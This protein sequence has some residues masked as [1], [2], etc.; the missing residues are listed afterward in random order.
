M[1]IF[2][3][4]TVTVL[5]ILF[6]QCSLN[7]ESTDLPW[8]QHGPLMVNPGSRIIHHR[9]GTP[10]LWLG[11]TAWGM[12]EWLTREDVDYYLNDRKSK[13]MNV[14][15]LCLFWG[16]RRDYPTRFTVNAENP[17]GH[18]AFLETDEIPDPLKPAIVRGGSADDPNDYWDHVD[19]C[20]NATQARGMVAAVLPFWG[21]RYVNASHADQSLP[22]FTAENI[23]QYTEFLGNRYADRPNIIWVNG[24]DVRADQN[25]DYL[26]LYRLAAEGLV[27]GVTGQDVAWHEQHPAWENLLITYHPSGAPMFNSSTWFH[28]DPWLD[29]NMIETHVHREK[30]A[31]AI[32]QDYNLSP[33][34]PTVMGEGHYE[35][36][37]GNKTAEAVHIRRQAYQTF[38]AGAAGHTYGG[39]FDEEG[40]GPLFAPTNNWKPLL[41]QPGASQLVHLERFLEEQ[42]WWTWEPVEN[43]I[44]K[45]RG[46]GELE[47]LVIQSNQNYLIYF[48]DNSECRLTINNKKQ[49]TWYNTRQGLYFHDKIETNLFRPPIDWEDAVLIF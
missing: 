10:F 32:H 18:K 12:T 24:G 48:P 17:Y 21:R 19:Y 33:V 26:P 38:F 35:G 40:N 41:E 30:L 22:V 3:H 1:K 43:V 14:V 11:C 29:F 2:Y 15:Q 37:T 42:E 47:K 20:M 5:G 44:V 4:I 25:G 31:D 9:D 49:A 46:E 23:K 27:K 7:E 16:K 28:T 45:G 34:K 36:R 8:E 13:G 39:G 6:L